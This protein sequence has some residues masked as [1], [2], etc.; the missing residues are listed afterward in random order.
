MKK[1][2]IAILIFGFVA[3]V[4]PV[5]ARAT[6]PVTL[7]FGFPVP[8]TSVDNTRG[9]GPW[10]QEVE[11]ASGGTL[12]IEFYPGPTLASERNIYE[13][14]LAGVSQISFSIFGPV[15]SEFPRTEVATL[16]FLTRDTLHLSIALWHLY[17][18][19]LLAPEFRKVKLLA[20]FSFPNAVLHTNKPIATLDDLKGLKVAASSRNTAEVALALGA[21]PVTLTPTE[22]Y[23]GIS[24]STVAGAITSLG[25]AKV[26]KLDEITHDH[27]EA[28]LGTAPG[29]VYMNKAAYAALPARAKHAIDEFSG[30][31]F[32]EK[33]GAANVWEQREEIADLKKTP[34]QHLSELSAAQYA[35]WEKRIQPVIAAWVKNTPDGAKVLAECRAEL[36]RLSATN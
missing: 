6:E 23:E 17:A 7:K 11:K 25:A 8:A 14:T 20:L 34:G 33:M 19:G 10:I 28:P 22:L 24:R 31:A 21:E 27:L 30:A 29:F 26:F 1:T 36:A 35:L 2:A 5:T 32:S 18:S 16:P 13:R 15:A 3:A 9:V 12:K 4:M